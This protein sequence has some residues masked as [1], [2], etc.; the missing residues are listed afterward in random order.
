MKNRQ[1]FLV[2]LNWGL[3]H[4]TRSVPIIKNFRDRG[5][6][7]LVGGSP[8]QL[9]IINQELPDIETI[10]FPH[11]K[12]KFNGKRNILI[13]FLIQL[14]AFLIQILRE[15]FAVKKVIR[16]F[17]IDLIV[18]DNCFGLW[19][20]N[21][22][23]IIIT[24]QLN[25]ILP[26]RL[27]L[28]TNPV[29]WINHR[30]IQKFDAC[31][32]PD[33]ENHEG[34]SGKLSHDIKI[35]IK[36]EY[37]GILSRFQGLIKT[38]KTIFSNHRKK[39][40]ILISGPENQRSIFEQTIKDQ[41]G[42]VSKEYEYLIVRGLPEDHSDCLPGW[43]NHLPSGELMEVILSADAII[44]RSGYSTIMDLL[45]LH[46]TALLV[47]TPGQSEQE[48]LAEYLSSRDLFCTMNQN[49]FELIPALEKIQKCKAVT[50]KPKR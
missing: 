33:V 14:P 11:L 47:P 2:P 4:V 42:Y 36:T 18:S 27:K 48:Y 50:K 23:S 46:K 19:N 10:K 20:K 32:I 12:V 28:L 29:N 15:H 5:D 7:V 43:H 8:S 31:W 9:A 44:C 21:I 35:N 13:S 26:D 22:E 30:F 3:G 40:L 17:N 6:F 25:I 41:L 24:H 45:T 34:F 39:L 16:K 38:D 1:V 49:E 37:L